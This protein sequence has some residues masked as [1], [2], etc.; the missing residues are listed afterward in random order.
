MNLRGMVFWLGCALLLAP[1]ARAQALRS[2]PLVLGD[3]ILTLGADVSVST[4]LNDPGFF[5]YTDYSHSALRLFRVDLTGAFAVN[6]HLAVLGEIRSENAGV[7]EAYGLYLRVHPWLR[8]TID[9]QVGRVPPIVRRVRA[10][11]IRR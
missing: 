5:N 10:P 6:A 1:G 9:I 3:G 4:G 2:E 8:R 11:R 7:P